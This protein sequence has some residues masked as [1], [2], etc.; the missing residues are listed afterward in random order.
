MEQEKP[1]REQLLQEI[2]H[3][4]KQ[5]A[6]LAE[7]LAASEE[8]FSLLAETSGDAL[9][10]LRFETMS[11]DFMSQGIEKLTGY[12]ASEIN[13]MSFS[14]L[15]QTIASPASGE[16][17]RRHLAERR[18]RGEAEEFR[19][20]YLIRTKGGEY[21]WLSDH[22]FPWRD[23]QG[24]LLGSVGIL[25]DITERKLMEEKL[26]RLATVD[27]LTGLYNRRHFLELAARELDRHRRYKSPFSLL[28]MDIDHFKLI[29]DQHGHQAGDQVLERLC[30]LWK[31]H[32]R[33]SDFLGRLGGEEFAVALVESPLTR[34]GQ[35]AERL[36]ALTEDSE[37]MVGKASLRVTISLGA[38]QLANSRED[39]S[40]LLRRADDALYA[41]KNGGRNRVELGQA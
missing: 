23:D 8:R 18:R 36:R 4:R 29:N 35:V 20:D 24:K 38:A 40:S 22:S 37:L 11:Y 1:S 33:A 28:V 32:M 39:L 21:K 2:A 41:A 5:A 26:R 16:L 17:S 10:H 6:E 27:H 7:A 30:A 34:A 19:A 31:E 3:L 13:G 25:T 15:V 14:R 9:Y 12:G